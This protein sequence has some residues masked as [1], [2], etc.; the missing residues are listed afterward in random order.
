M[1]LSLYAAG[2]AMLILAPLA[3]FSVLWAVLPLAAAFLI[4]NGE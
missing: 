1:K 2:G 3:G 4:D